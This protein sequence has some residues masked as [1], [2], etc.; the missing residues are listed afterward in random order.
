MLSNCGNT[1]VIVPFL[2][3]LRVAN[4]RALTSKE[5]ISGSISSIHFDTPTESM[6][7]DKIDSEGCQMDATE[8]SG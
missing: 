4:R 1:Q 3:T 5:I 8:K 6:S 7:S 2:I